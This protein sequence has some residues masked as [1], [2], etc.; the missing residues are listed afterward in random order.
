MNYRIVYYG[1]CFEVQ[2]RARRL[3]FWSKWETMTMLGHNAEPEGYAR[4]ATFEAAREW[5]EKHCCHGK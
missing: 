3:L 1:M 4:F 2:E 5:F